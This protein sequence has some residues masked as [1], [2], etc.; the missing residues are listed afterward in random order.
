MATTTAKAKKTNA[1]EVDPAELSP[2]LAGVTQETVSTVLGRSDIRQ[3]ASSVAA[4]K[5]R[6][7]R[8][9]QDFEQR[10][11]NFQANLRRIAT[12]ESEIDA[13][14]DTYRGLIDKGDAPGADGVLSGI[15]RERRKL[16]RLAKEIESGGSDVSDLTEQ[17]EVLSGELSRIDSVTR[18]LAKFA[19]A[20]HRAA[21][22]ISVSL[23][24]I[25]EKE[26]RIEQVLEEATK[27][28]GEILSE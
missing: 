26:F 24:A 14:R 13:M 25:N 20:L 17:R 1:V 4:A 6:A 15:S 18:D 27:K 2:M 23:S 9:M 7:A 22:A 12:I 11:G 5:R 28:A 19:E 21:C 10:L 16:V 8:L 3:V